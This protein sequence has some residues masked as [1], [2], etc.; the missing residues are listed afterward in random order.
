MI[1]YCSNK[2]MIGESQEEGSVAQIE[3]NQNSF[4]DVPG[5]KSHGEKYAMV[6]T[7]TVCN[8][9]SAKQISKQ[10]YHHG[11]VLI[12][13]PGCQNLHLI[14]DHIGIFETKGWSIESYL[15]ETGGNVRRVS[16][17]GVLELTKEDILGNNSKITPPPEE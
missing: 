1:R 13:C 16:D 3:G 5:V 7:C 6:Y 11:C 10:G 14:A 15:A 8:T 12:R 4:S 17:D 2:A 9:R